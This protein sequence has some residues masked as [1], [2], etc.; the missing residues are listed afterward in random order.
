MPTTQT[1]ASPTQGTR[2][3]PAVAS[4]ALADSLIYLRDRWKWNGSKIA[5][6]L[7]LSPTTVNGWLRMRTIPI[8]GSALS[9]DVQAV[10]H[11]IAIHRSLEAMFADPFHQVEWL[12]TQHPDLDN[13]A[14]L[15]KMTSSMADLIS[16]RQYLDY[17]RGRGA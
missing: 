2:L 8:T 5:R 11:L 4:K 9:N 7:H 17:V 14:P 6:A 1:Q 13:T 12:N 16:L 10:I 15:E 3:D